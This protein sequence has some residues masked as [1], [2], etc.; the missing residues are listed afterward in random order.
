MFTGLP[1]LIDATACHQPLGGWANAERQTV[2]RESRPEESYYIACDEHF[3]DTFGPELIEWPTLRQ[4]VEGTECIINECAADRLGFYLPAG[5]G[6]PR[7]SPL[8]TRI[9]VEWSGMREVV[10]VVRNFQH[11]TL[12]RGIEP[13]I[14]NAIAVPVAWYGLN[15]WLSEFAYRI[16]LGPSVLLLGII[17][18]LALAFG[19]V[20]WQAWSASRMNPVDVLRAA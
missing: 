10:G 11:G 9:S 2:Y 14:A 13:L 4:G 19:S 18:S 7:V 17:V 20:A 15:G 6:L 8:G 3:L 16:D 12:R 5:S 1:G